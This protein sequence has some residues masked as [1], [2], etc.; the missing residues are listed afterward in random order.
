MHYQRLNKAS[1]ASCCDGLLCCFG[2]LTCLGLRDKITRKLVFFPPEPLYSFHTA[3]VSYPTM[4]LIDEEGTEIVPYSHRNFTL[5]KF[6]SR[7]GN[8][9]AAFF[10]SHPK[11]KC[12]LMFSHGNAADL[13][14]CRDH[15]IDMSYALSVSLFAFDYSGYGLSSGQPSH[16]SVV[17]DAHSAYLFLINDL[18]VPTDSIVLYGQSLGSAAVCSLASRVDIQVAG[19]ILHSPF[20][21]CVRVVRD[22]QR[23][24]FFD[25][26]PNIDQ[27][28]RIITPLLIIHGEK[29]EEIPVTHAWV[30]YAISPQFF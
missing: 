20:T 6:P 18:G 10:I 21:S 13:G 24:P 17:Q 5:H 4:Y 7:S 25:I 23:T 28:K 3:S 2:F 14:S 29:D 12:T 30:S 27:V 1:M 19:A 9:I 22:V 15:L 26:F 16:R 11:A 8:T